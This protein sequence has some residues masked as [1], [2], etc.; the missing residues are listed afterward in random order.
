MVSVMEFLRVS[1]EGLA[2]KDSSEVE[3][4][5]TD[6]F[7]MTTPR[8]SLNRQEFL[9]WVAFGG[10][11]TVPSDFEVIYE[12]DDIAAVYHSVQSHNA[13]GTQAMC[14]GSKRDG[15]FSVWRAAS[16]G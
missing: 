16:A 8:V 5:I 13:L 15:K 4:F 11:P 2:I 10:S 7:Q 1:K 6:D 12:N 14:V 9:D 3:K